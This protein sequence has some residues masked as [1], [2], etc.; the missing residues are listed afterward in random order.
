MAALDVRLLPT[1]GLP[2]RSKNKDEYTV[3]KYSEFLQNSSGT[4]SSG[5][6]YSHAGNQAH[7]LGRIYEGQE[8]WRDAIQWHGADLACQQTFLG[9]AE[10]HGHNS[11]TIKAVNDQLFAYQRLAHCWLQAGQ[12]RA[13]A[14]Q[15]THMHELAVARASL[16]SSKVLASECASQKLLGEVYLAAANAADEDAQVDDEDSD[17]TASERKVHALHGARLA[18]SLRQLAVGCFSTAQG[19]AQRLPASF[20]DHAGEARTRGEERAKVL[21]SRGA[22]HWDAEDFDKATGA[23]CAALRAMDGST[24]T[25]THEL[26]ALVTYNLSKIL[27]QSRHVHDSKKKVLVT[28]PDGG[29]SRVEMMTALGYARAAVDQYQALRGC[30]K[31]GLA[32][33]LEQCVSASLRAGNGKQAVAARTAQVAWLEKK[34][35]GGATAEK[36]RL[37]ELEAAF[38]ELAATTGHFERLRGEATR[39]AGAWRTPAAAATTAGEALEVAT[40]LRELA[41]GRRGLELAQDRL[42]LKAVRAALSAL[43]VEREVDARGGHGFSAPAAAAAAGV[44]S[45]ERAEIVGRVQELHTL[46]EELA[47]GDDESSVRDHGLRVAHKRALIELAKAQ[48]GAGSS[49]DLCDL[50]DLR[51]ELSRALMAQARAEPQLEARDGLRRE[52]RQQCETALD[53]LGATRAKV[54]AYANTRQPTL[55]RSKGRDA[56][57]GPDAPPEQVTRVIDA[58]DDLETVLRESNALDDAE[59]RLKEL[60]A[61]FL[62]WIQKAAPTTR[63]AQ[64]ANSKTVSSRAVHAVGPASSSSQPASSADATRPEAPKRRLAD[65]ADIVELSAP[66]GGAAAPSAIE[67]EQA[68]RQA[69]K[70]RRGEYATALHAKL[71]A[72]RAEARANGETAIVATRMARAARSSPSAA[73][74]AGRPEEFGKEEARWTEPADDLMMRG[75]EPQER[76]RRDEE[77]HD[78]SRPA[79]GPKERASE[80]VNLDTSRR[81][82]P[83]AP[84]IARCSVVAMGRELPGPGEFYR[85]P[86]PT[87]DAAVR[88]DDERELGTVGWLL[89]RAVR[90]LRQLYGLEA[91]HVHSA[92][93]LHLLEDCGTPLRED[94]SIWSLLHSDDN[95][96]RGVGS[97]TLALRL[98]VD[99][100]RACAPQDAY[101][102]HCARWTDPS[103]RPVAPCAEVLAALGGA[104]TARRPGSATALAAGHLDLSCLAAFGAELRPVLLTVGGLLLG[105]DIRTLTMSV[106]RLDSQ[107]LGLLCRQLPQS[108]QLRELD[109]SCQCLTTPALGHL[110]RCAERRALPA[111]TSL[112][113]SHNPLL[114]GFDGTLKSPPEAVAELPTGRG[115]WALGT[116][117]LLDTM[118]GDSAGRAMADALQSAPALCQ[119]DLR[120]NSPP[121]GCMGEEAQA[122]IEAAWRASGKLEAGLAIGCWTA[123]GDA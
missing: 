56:D 118:A 8:R 50:V 42:A 87:S 32:D 91:A 49:A 97:P 122:A 119:L 115:G 35:P 113:L 38:S 112:N 25:S 33:A 15:L 39:I 68:R 123:A 27:E 6:K 73:A 79:V 102:Q 34:Q 14:E 18:E 81:H 120:Y 48:R 44:A 10:R 105:S 54:R 5:L 96:G 99:G 20:E 101:E 36:A 58:L 89:D 60:N 41:E 70:A 77:V 67:E 74:A 64:L 121:T 92:T 100:L 103:G 3:S 17:E 57:T 46:G 94:R 86:K 82:T 12:H 45:G 52:A 75:G 109:F 93:R 28:E 4:A 63:I 90:D 55:A 72:D 104:S 61:I 78:E 23:Y 95:S 117:S 88:E 19:A 16:G 26:Q 43:G 53:Q 2:A 71:E 51:L 7:H 40:A 116:L 47:G 24:S 37:R 29:E 85:L 107:S 84:P 98:E 11:D 22:A 80:K 13:A 76:Y 114:H 21:L 108:C 106:G 66:S 1:A 9:H 62:R 69:A 110:L 59:C 30:G 65:D 83:S 111:L 31:A